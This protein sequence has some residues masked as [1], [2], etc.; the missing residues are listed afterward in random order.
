MSL[1]AAGD[2]LRDEIDRYLF[3]L[4]DEEGVSDSDRRVIESAAQI[5]GTTTEKAED[6]PRRPRANFG[7]LER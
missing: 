3:R 6:K 5:L 7:S 4:R 2:R 1:A